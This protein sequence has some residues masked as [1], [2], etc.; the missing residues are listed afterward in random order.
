MRLLVLAWE[1]PPLGVGGLAQHVFEL[2]RALADE[3]NVVD[4]ITRGD[5]N[6]LQNEVMEKVN[7]WRVIPYEWGAERGFVDWAYRLNFALAEQGV[8]LCRVQGRYDLVHAH[9]WMVGPAARL[10]KHTCYMP[11]VATIHATEFGR[12]GGLHTEEQNQ[13]S[14]ME[15]WLTYE[16]WKVICCSQYMLDELKN[17]FQLPADKVAVIPNGIRAEAYGTSGEQVSLESMGLNTQD[18]IV[19]FVGRLVPEK[20]VQVLLEA[21]PAIL[22]QFPRTRFVIAGKGPFQAQLKAKALELNLMEQVNFV[23][24]IDDLQRNALYQAASVA[25]FPSIY[26]PFGIVALEAMVSKTPVIVSTAG[27]LDEIVEHERDGL[28]VCPGDPVSLAFQI[29]RLL[30]DRPWADSLAKKA[31]QKAVKEYSWKTISRTTEGVF[32]EIVLSPENTRWQQTMQE[33]QAHQDFTIH[34]GQ[35]EPVMPYFV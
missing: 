26:E 17:L 14:Q 21:A 19:F 29:N 35:N 10:L 34:R 9:D 16:A 28:K 18:R 7:V 12:Q 8:R 25:V 20:G 27:G 13:I 32:R 4:V 5:G 33:E 23:G 11:L 31:Y 22:E 3:G 1:F 6:Q 15:W 30:A 24:Y 2:S